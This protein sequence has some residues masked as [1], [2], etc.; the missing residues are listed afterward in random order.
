MPKRK[1]LKYRHF[2]SRADK[3][4]R[5]FV[6][7]AGRNFP[8]F[9][10]GTEPACYGL[11][12]LFDLETAP[13]TSSFTPRPLVIAPSILASDFSKLG[14]EVRAVDAAGADWIHLDVMDGHFVPNISYGPDVIK[15]LR[16][17]TKKI[18]DA[19]LMI[20][21]CDPYLEAFAKAGCDH[22]TVHAEAGPHLHRSLQAIRALGKK[23]GVSLNPSTPLN[24]IE[25]V[26]DMIDLVLI[27]SVNPGF[28]GQAFIPSTLGKLQ[29]LRAMLAGRPVDIEVD[30]GVAPDVAGPLAAAGANAFVAGS[31]VFKGGTMDAYR[32]NIAAIRDAAAQARGEAI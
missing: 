13:M 20:S 8:A 2:F 17:H 32:S 26:L 9:V 30:G 3:L 24:V 19:H 23:A 4:S 31:A 14:D 11:S 10:A 1:R 29:D 6:P 18:F 27:M 15:A 16:P 5:H 28:G 12:S 21:P 25:Y 22:I 7:A